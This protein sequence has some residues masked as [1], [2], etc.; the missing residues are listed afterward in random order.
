MVMPAG[1]AKDGPGAKARDLQG[2]AAEKARIA[3]T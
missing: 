2:F 1:F 3:A